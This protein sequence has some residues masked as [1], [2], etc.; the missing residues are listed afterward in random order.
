MVNEIKGTWY[1]VTAFNVA[2]LVRERLED[3]YGRFAGK[4]LVPAPKWHPI[5]VIFLLCMFIV[6]KFSKT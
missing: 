2:C 4:Y 6:L 1:K 5:A 3:V